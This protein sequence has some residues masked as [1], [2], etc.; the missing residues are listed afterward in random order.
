M[1]PAEAEKLCE[2]LLGR[3]DISPLLNLGSSTARFR[4]VAKP[5]IEASLFAPLRRAGIE[6]VHCDIKQDDG[7]DLV[8]DV[9]DPGFAQT[10]MARHFRAVLLANLLEH[11]RDPAAI[12][13]A[14]EHIA[15]P[16]GLILATVPQ[17]YPFHA[18]PIDTGYRPSPRALAALFPAS[19]AI[20]LATIEGGTFGDR[21]SAQGRRLWREILSTAMWL[22]ISPVRPRTA[23]AKLHRWLWLRRPFRV[24]IA[25]LRVGGV[26]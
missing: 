20:C 7:V 26:P 19:E 13:S 15:G 8:G 3:G 17:S 21:M 6:V 23:A 1:F 22:L 24:S 16:G 5:H 9:T 25:L 2:L 11:V 10:L 14:C 4:T 12:A 18:D